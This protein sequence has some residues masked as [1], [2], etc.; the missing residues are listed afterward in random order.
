M[1]PTS[2]GRKGTKGEF[3]WARHGGTK[4]RK[5]LAIIKCEQEN[6][7]NKGDRILTT[8]QAVLGILELPWR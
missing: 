1:K 6:R 5:A 2:L 8:S 7:A 4:K 3:E